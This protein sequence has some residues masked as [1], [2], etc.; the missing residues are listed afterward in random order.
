MKIEVYRRQTDTPDDFFFARISDAAARTEK[1]ENQLRQ[2]AIFVHEM[3]SALRLMVGYSNIY[4]ELCQIF[5]VQ[6][7]TNALFIELGKV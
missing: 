5:I 2:Q 7:P 4:C 3:Q 1:R 6:S